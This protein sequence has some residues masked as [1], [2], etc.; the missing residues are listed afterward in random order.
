MDFSWF[1]YVGFRTSGTG[2]AA[3]ENDL[4]RICKVKH[5]R[6]LRASIGWLR[7]SKRIDAPR[8]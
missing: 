4:V 2:R 3:Y 8:A 1:S 5:E 7:R 6:G